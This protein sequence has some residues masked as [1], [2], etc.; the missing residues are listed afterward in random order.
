MDVYGDVNLVLAGKV[1]PKADQRLNFKNIA[2]GLGAGKLSDEIY[3]ETIIIDHKAHLFFPNHT[4]TLR[5]TLTTPF[6]LA[7]SK[8]PTQKLPITSPTTIE[9]LFSNLLKK[10]KEV[11]LIG[12]VHFDH[13]SVAYY[14]E[15]PVH[16]EPTLSP[17]NKSKYVAIE[18]YSNEK[19]FLVGFGTTTP[20]AKAFYQNPFDANPGVIS[21][22]HVLTKHGARH[23]FT[24]SVIGQGVLALSID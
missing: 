8:T 23:L 2:Y 11:I 10:Y 20:N 14:K 13:L 4:L 17:E 7:T 19:A 6:L 3:G 18:T 5:E 15:S 1:S 21:H 22:T 12:E 24:D 9:A 16:N